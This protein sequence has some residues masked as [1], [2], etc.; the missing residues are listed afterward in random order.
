M[1]HLERPYSDFPYLLTGADTWILPAGFNG[2]NWINDPVGAG[3]FIVDKYTP[4]QGITYRKNPY[5]WD[6]CGGEAGRSERDVLLFRPVRT[7]RVPKRPN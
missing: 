7:A 5:Y 4:G 3:Q 6:A 2:T 1:F